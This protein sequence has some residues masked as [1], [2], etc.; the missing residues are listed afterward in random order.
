ML[1]R[2]ITLFLL[3][4]FSATLFGQARSD[5]VVMKNGDRLTCEIVSLSDGVLFVKLDY[6]DGSVALQWSKVARLESS[7]L[8]IVKTE[9]GAVYTG[10]LSS[11]DAV[12]DQ[13]ITI[14]VAKPEQPKVELP[15]QDVITI[16]TT[17]ENFIERFN[18]DINFGV[19]YAKGNQAT[20]YNLNSSIEYPRDRWRAEAKFSSNFSSNKGAASTSR[21]HFS[22]RADR[23]LRWNNYFYTGE[24]GLLQSSEQGIQ[25]QTSLG[26]GVGYYI[27]N[28]RHVKFSV[29]GGVGW[30]HTNYSG[31][32]AS[33]ETQNSTAAI[34]STNLRFFRFK[35]TSLDLDAVLLPSLS[36]PG[37]VYF[38]IKQNYYVKI[39]G[40]LSWNISF[41]GNWDNRPPVGLSGSDYGTSTGLG[42][43]FGNR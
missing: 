12:G 34:I 19:S 18:G 31:S 21:N 33:R 1:I 14:E 15:S 8:F 43:S 3:M 27:R 22:V 40:D 2:I 6:A 20:Q 7:R 36:E 30:Q 35:K 29:V 39:F 11:I 9:K 16:G 5:V 38:K 13:P 17:A 41:Y 28:S 37:R 24:F 32:G 42:W 4:T 25:R 10:A 23:L 26:G